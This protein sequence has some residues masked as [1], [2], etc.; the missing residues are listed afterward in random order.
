MRFALS[1]MLMLS[2]LG[3]HEEH[4]LPVDPPATA[5]P[6]ESAP[7]AAAPEEAD[8]G[9]APEPPADRVPVELASIT[10]GDTLRVRLDG[11]SER[12]RLVGIDTPETEN[13]P[14]GPQPFADEATDALRSLVRDRSLSLAFDTERRDRFGRL[15]AYLYADDTFVNAEM[16][17]EGWARP[18]TV[19]PN[20]RHAERFA[21]LAA[22][23]RQA[24]RG[25]WRFGG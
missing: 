19:P 4:V 17:R 18:L 21:A 9:E 5:P 15:L 23:A 7:E 12:V 20:V 6:D 1:L 10:D 24:R 16:I 11:R 3:C 13:S 8:S 14:R 22:E 25:I 2:L